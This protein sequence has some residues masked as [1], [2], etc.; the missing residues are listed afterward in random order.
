MLQLRPSEGSFRLLTHP[1][2][3]LDKAALSD[4]D[5]HVSTCLVIA[6]YSKALIH[7]INNVC[8][9]VATVLIGVFGIENL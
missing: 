3:H 6:S 8:Q 2:Q 7:F 9:T 4:E 5:K 1:V